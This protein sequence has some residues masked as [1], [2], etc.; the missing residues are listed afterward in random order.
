MYSSCVHCH[1]DSVVLLFLR[2]QPDL[3]DITGDSTV[4]ACQDIIREFF[5]QEN[6]PYLDIL[7]AYR[8]EIKGKPQALWTNHDDSHPNGHGHRIIYKYLH[9]YLDENGF[10][11]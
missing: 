3:H 9:A 5:T 6:I 11:Y 4:Q 7:E 1:V 8:N 2:L 10:I